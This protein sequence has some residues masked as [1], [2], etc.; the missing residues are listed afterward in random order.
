MRSGHSERLL[1]A[2]ADST[3]ARTYRAYAESDV[4]LA[5]DVIDELRSRRGE[6][7]DEAL[8]ALENARREYQELNRIC[9]RH[10]ARQVDDVERAG[11]RH[12]DLESAVIVYDIKN[13]V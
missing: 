8:L 5:E 6:V 7:P 10:A 1:Q 12:S 11:G 4:R 9:L 13:P 3:A 2:D